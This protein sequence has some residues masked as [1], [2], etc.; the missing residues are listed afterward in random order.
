MAQRRGQKRK[1]AV[2]V[3]L[4][5]LTR[6]ASDSPLGARLLQWEDVPTW[7]STTLLRPARAQSSVQRKFNAAS[8]RPPYAIVI[9][10]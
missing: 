8:D 10:L 6:F 2:E 5:P 9:V 3:Q 1:N 4:D 7:G